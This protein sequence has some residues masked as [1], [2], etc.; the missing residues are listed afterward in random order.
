MGVVLEA[1]IQQHRS[2]SVP[3]TDEAEPMNLAVEHL[4]LFRP[5]KEYCSELSSQDSH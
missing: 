2:V 1:E 4:I 3:M 5:P